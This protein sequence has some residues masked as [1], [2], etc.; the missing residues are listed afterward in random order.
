MTTAVFKSESK[1][2][3]KLLVDLAEK[4]GMESKILTEEQIEEIGMMN[5][6]KKGDTGEYIDS[7]KILKKLKKKWK[8]KLF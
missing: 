7:K 4:L 6:I 3:L 2:N 8:S 1:Q 5:A